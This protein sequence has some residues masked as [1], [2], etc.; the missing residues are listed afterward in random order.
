MGLTRFRPPSLAQRA[1]FTA[2]Q[3]RPA[4]IERFLGAFAGI[5]PIDAY[6]SAG[7]ILRVLA[8]R[9]RPV[10]ELATSLRA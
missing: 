6:L 4:E 8:S 5:T 7:N 1:L 9:E 10:C 2:L 3:G